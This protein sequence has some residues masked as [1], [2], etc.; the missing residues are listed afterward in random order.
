MKRFKLTTVFAYTV[1]ISGIL[2]L[3]NCSHDIE[4]LPDTWEK[5]AEKNGLLSSSSDVFCKVNGECIEVSENM[6]LAAGGEVV[7]SCGSSSSRGGSSSSRGS[8]NSSSSRGTNSSSSRGN[9]SSSSITQS[10]SSNKT[11][12]CSGELYNTA[13]QYCSNGVVKT[14]GS[15]TDGDGNTY[16]T[17][18]IGTQ[19]WTAENLNYVA[20]GSK[21]YTDNKNPDETANCKKYG[22]L[23]SW[24][25]AKIVCP[26]GWSLP[27]NA[28]W[29]KL[30]RYV[31]GNTSTNSPYNSSTAG[32][33]LKATSGWDPFGDIVNLDTYGFSALPGGYGLSNDFNDVDKYGY[34][35][36]YSEHDTNKTDAYHLEMNYNDDKSMYFCESKSLLHSVRCMKDEVQYE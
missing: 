17:V 21:C 11:P 32:K 14:Y 8:V 6:C 10:S 1:L 12:T 23:Y 18:V 31:D 35:W 19:T 16:K 30:M 26:S 29:D 13:T 34:W 5:Y 22:R 28:D 24:A 2:T 4:E 20:E 15:M 3:A 27:S 25:T 33:Y 9:S 36:S 7:L